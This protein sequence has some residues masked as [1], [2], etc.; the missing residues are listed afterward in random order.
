MQAHTWYIYDRGG[1]HKSCKF[2]V[3]ISFWTWTT[4]TFHH[5]SSIHSFSGQLAPACIRLAP[6]KTSSTT[7]ILYMCVCVCACVSSMY[8]YVV[9][10]TLSNFPAF[11]PR[12]IINLLAYISSKVEKHAEVNIAKL[13]RTVNF[14]YTQVRTPRLVCL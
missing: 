10:S 11:A 4:N 1:G 7:L 6:N 9:D 12:L 13:T 14:I 2:S 8:V 5:G 3:F